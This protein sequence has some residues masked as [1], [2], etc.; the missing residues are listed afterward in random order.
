MLTL[1]LPPRSILL[2][3]CWL[4]LAASASCYL[5]DLPTYRCLVGR[6]VASGQ[7]SAV[8]HSERVLARPPVRLPDDTGCL[9]PRSL[10]RFARRHLVD[11]TD[12]GSSLLFRLG[13]RTTCRGVGAAAYLKRIGIRGR[14]AANVV[15][16]PQQFSGA[17]V[18]DPGG[19]H[20]RR[21]TPIQQRLAFRGRC[22]L[23][24]YPIALAF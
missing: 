16:Q 19:A 17:A 2:P 12:D 9:P 8:A 23:Q 15:R 21:R 18:G 1:L 6:V 10:Q 13:Y 11:W 5:C 24:G 7:S 4:L 3:A 14:R 20:D 22:R